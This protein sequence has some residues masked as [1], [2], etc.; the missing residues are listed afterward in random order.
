MEK[1]SR[2]LVMQAIAAKVLFVVVV[3]YLGSYQ[4]RGDRYGG[5]DVIYRSFRTQAEARFFVPAAKLESLIFA[6]PVEAY[7]GV[8]DEPLS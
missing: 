2:R 1:L 7:G 5:Q 4:L 3:V 6:K 8:V